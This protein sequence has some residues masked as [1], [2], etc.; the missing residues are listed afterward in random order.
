M[1][2][3]EYRA[4]R[5]SISKRGREPKMK[6]L[7]EGENSKAVVFLSD[8]SE[9]TLLLSH[10]YMIRFMNGTYITDNTNDIAAIRKHAAFG[11]CVWEGKFPA[12]IADRIKRDSQELTRNKVQ[13]EPLS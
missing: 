13:F 9:L 8:K 2:N 5:P 3:S 12:Y 4:I 11:E 10:N 6:E 7:K 1:A